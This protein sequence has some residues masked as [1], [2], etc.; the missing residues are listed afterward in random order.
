MFI[1]Y[2]GTEDGGLL[3]GTGDGTSGDQPESTTGL[4]GPGKWHLVTASVDR[5]AGVVQLYVDGLPQGSGAAKTDFTTNSDM[6][7]GRFTSP[8]FP[9]NGI[10]NEARIHSGIDDTNWVWA[11]YMTVASNSVFSAYSAVNTSV[12]PSANL[13]IQ[14][15]GGGK[16]VLNWTEGTLQSASV[17][18]GPYTNVTGATAPYTTT[19]SGAQ[20]FYRVQLP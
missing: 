20:Q 8:N 13:T 12:A 11:D 6:Y 18:T 4:I 10:M 15:I 19:V 5:G 7:L 9:M 17:L 1:N 14:Y 16:V 3:V 2:Y